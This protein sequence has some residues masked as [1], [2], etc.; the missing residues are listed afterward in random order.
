V[1]DR[2]NVN[3]TASVTENEMNQQTQNVFATMYF[4]TRCFLSFS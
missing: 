1:T 2:P 3:S 4:L